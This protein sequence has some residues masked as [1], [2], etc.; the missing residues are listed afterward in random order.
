MTATAI[1]DPHADKLP[2]RTQAERSGAMR[3][4]LAQAAYE[5][6]AAG[7]LNALRMRNVADHAGVSQGALLH[8][9]PDKKALILATVEQALTYARDEST[10]WRDAGGESRE[11]V[12][13]AMLEEF[14]GF[15]FSD[16]FW[17]AM[18]ITME[19][20]RD[21]ELGVAVR[22]K[23]ASLRVPIYA[24]WAARLA[25]AGWT[26]QQAARIVRSGAGMLSG[27]AMRRFWADADDI[28]AEVEQ[29]WI[30]HQLRAG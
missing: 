23:V 4:R 17:V 15:F 19:A 22:A 30:A 28:S 2:R 5:T 18:G 1:P 29:D 24:A 21:P 9:F 14:R 3:G 27:A 6:I 12:L 7:G 11:A 25:A 10:S 26:P 20:L 13:V 8:H 16:R